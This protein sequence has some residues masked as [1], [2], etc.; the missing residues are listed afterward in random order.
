MLI[1]FS[2]QK[3]QLSDFLHQSIIHYAQKL[4]KQAITV[5]ASFKIS[6][7]IEQVNSSSIIGFYYCYI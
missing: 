3:A 5:T 6:K 7:Q 1:T 2:L 4:C